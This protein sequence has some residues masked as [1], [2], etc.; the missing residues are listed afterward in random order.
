M[1]RC[2]Q[3]EQYI[4][5]MMFCRANIYFLILINWPLKIK[6]CSLK[7]LTLTSCSSVT[8]SWGRSDKAELFWF[9]NKHM[10]I[11]LV[12]S[13]PVKQD[14]AHPVHHFL[15]LLHFFNQGHF[16][17]HN[18]RKTCNGHSKYRHGTSRTG[19]TMFK[20]DMW[21]IQKFAFSYFKLQ[22]TRHRVSPKNVPLQKVLT[23]QK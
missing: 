12:T 11:L 6:S 19:H 2:L 8:W 18:R 20:L 21:V 1:N 14:F 23:S 13:L 16:L 4:G 3:Y 10:F 22:F 17:Q 7:L 5:Y 15:H 9:R